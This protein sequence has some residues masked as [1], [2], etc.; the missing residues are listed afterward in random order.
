VT[1]AC[2]NPFRA[3]FTHGIVHDIGLDVSENR[4][5]IERVRHAMTKLRPWWQS[6]RAA[7]VRGAACARCA[8]PPVPL[9]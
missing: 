4:A 8:D 7:T 2:G 3:G 1:D 9:H 6:V 5:L